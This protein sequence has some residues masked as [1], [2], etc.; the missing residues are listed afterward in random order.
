MNKL[1]VTAADWDKDKDNLYS[2]RRT[3]F[4][5]EQD[6]PEEAEIDEF[7]P[8]SVHVL[9]KVGNQCVGTGRVLPDGRIGRIAVLKDYRSQNI[10]SEIVL[11]LLD[12]ARTMNF[13]QTELSAQVQAVEFYK[14]LGFCEIGDVYMED[15]IEHIKMVR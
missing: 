11:K 8:V 4:V 6:V 10:G 7:D 12:I 14:K 15:G 2:V 1:S 13:D 9:A 5:E 3:V